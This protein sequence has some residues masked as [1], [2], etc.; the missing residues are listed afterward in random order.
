MIIVF[1]QVEYDGILIN[2]LTIF[3]VSMV[4]KIPIWKMSAVDS[5]FH[6]IDK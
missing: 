5:D 6:L 3:Y 2:F 1:I 4:R